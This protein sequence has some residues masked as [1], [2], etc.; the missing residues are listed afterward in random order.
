MGKR[1]KHADV[2]GPASV[3]TAKG[4]KRVK[5]S[6]DSPH[7]SA[8]TQ[9]PNAVKRLQAIAA[10]A[11]R[12]WQEAVAARTPIVIEGELKDKEWLASCK[13]SN[14]YLRS[15]AGTCKIL[16]EQKFGD[17]GAFGKGRKVHMTFGELVQQLQQ[18]ND[19]LYLTTQ[20]T[21]VDA[22]GLPNI[23]APPV[24]R[25]RQDFPVRPECMGCLIPQQINLWMGAA[26]NGA[27]SGLHH[28]FHDNLYILLRGRKRFRLYPPSE[29]P[30]MYT[31]GHLKKIYPNGRI[32]YAGQG[33]VLEDGSD[34]SEVRRWQQEQAVEAELAAA[35]EGVTAGAKGAKGRLARA[36]QAFEALLDAQL[37][38]R[39]HDPGEDGCSGSEG[40]PADL[41]D[42]YID[43]DADDIDS[44]DSQQAVLSL[45][46]RLNPGQACEGLGLGVQQ[47]AS[48]SPTTKQLVWES[49]ID[50]S[51]PPSFSQ[52]DL[53]SLTETELCMQF[54]M[55]PVGFYLSDM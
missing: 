26:R 44:N 33:M 3:T 48:R 55:F 31:H 13:W 2:A 24:S 29:A 14:D 32:V 19:S 51:N 9:Q 43:S 25:L 30:H 49:V 47:G 15:T 38:C 50:D 34:T 36:E 23:M 6:A 10:G 20:E 21:G 12:L 7:I 45:Q 35:E 54:P 28:D 37:R 11:E 41:Q 52:V 8:R 18:G 16:V 17:N 22:A 1:K 40:F 5:T 39:Q 4:K 42:D 53:S 27:S 46:S